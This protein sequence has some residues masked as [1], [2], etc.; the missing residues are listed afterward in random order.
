MARGL[1]WANSKGQLEGKVAG[2]VCT[3]PRWKIAKSR[4]NLDLQDREDPPHCLQEAKGT[5][6]TN[7]N[8]ISNFLE[9]NFPSNYLF[10]ENTNDQQEIISYLKGMFPKRF[11]PAPIEYQKLQRH[12]TQPYKRNRT[13]YLF[14]TKKKQK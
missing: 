9:P 7:S 14:S 5:H 6:E 1:V 3:D 10:L 8:A 13:E 2:Q 4:V 12:L 11:F